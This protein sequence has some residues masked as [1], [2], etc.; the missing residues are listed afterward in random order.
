MPWWAFT[1]ACWLAASAGFAWGWAARA[2]IP[3]S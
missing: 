1:L 2:R 3:R